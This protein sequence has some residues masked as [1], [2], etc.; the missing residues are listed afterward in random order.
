MIWVWSVVILA[1]LI[2][3]IMT[4]GNLVSIWFSFAAFIALILALFNVSDTIQIIVFSIISIALILSIR[5]L[6]SKYFRGNIT[7]TNADALIGR[8]VTLIS[9][10]TTSKW[11]ETKI[12]GVVWN[13]ISFDGSEIE[14]DALVSILAIEG[15]KLVVRKVA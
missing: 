14:Q 4:V 3:E 9:P 11:G 2:I 10:I 13:A 7:P 6:A 15:A 8:Q 12:S 1:S 5:P